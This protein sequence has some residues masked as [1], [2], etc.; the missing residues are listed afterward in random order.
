MELNEG[1]FKVMNIRGHKTIAST[2]SM[3]NSS[4]EQIGLRETRRENDLWVIVNIKLK[5]DH[6]VI[7]AV[8]K[9]TSFLGML[10]R[11]FVHWGAN[12]FLWLYLISGPLSIAL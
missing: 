8:L 3:K 11:T 7:Q 6:Q 9:A 12:L 10:K 2:L 5:W 1:K 4:G